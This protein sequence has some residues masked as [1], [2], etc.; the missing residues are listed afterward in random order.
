MCKEMPFVIKHYYKLNSRLFQSTRAQILSDFS[1]N[2]ENFFVFQIGANDGFIG[3]PIHKFIFKFGWAG[4]LLEPQPF[5]FQ[6]Y[7]LKTYA[8]QNQIATINC[9]IGEKKGTKTLY[10][11]SFSTHRWATGLSSFSKT[12]FNNLFDNGYIK[13]KA[14]QQGVELPKM[15][16]CISENTVEVLTFE[17]LLESYQ[18]LTIDLLQIDAEG[19]DGK[20]LSIF[21]FQKCKPRF[22][23]FEHSHMNQT[24][25]KI[26]S[27]KLKNLGYECS[28]LGNDTFCILNIS[29]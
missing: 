21:P 26:I 10:S 17:D 28:K 27:D 12:G 13:K 14:K 24:E 11:L 7:L 22:I 29:N 23:N 3:D 16:D 18:I 8:S 25:Y 19:Y 20:L 6:N 1:R 4:I 15:N 5:V 9:A 2:N